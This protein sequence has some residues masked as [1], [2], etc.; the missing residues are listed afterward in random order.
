MGRRGRRDEPAWLRRL[1]E[2]AFTRFSELGFPSAKVEAWKYTNTAPIAEKVWT[3]APR[4][5]VGDAVSERALA[6]WRIPGAVEIV[7]VNGTFSKKHSRVPVAQG[8][9]T[10]QSLADL[11]P[12]HVPNTEKLS[13]AFTEPIDRYEGLG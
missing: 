10:V 13:T 9:V 7:F 4:L 11:G 2:E 1:R 8:G 6:P 3:P 12:L 5:A